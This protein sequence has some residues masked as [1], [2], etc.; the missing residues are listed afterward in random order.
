MDFPSVRKIAFFFFFFFFFPPPPPSSQQAGGWKA[1]VC[2]VRAAESRTSF[3]VQRASAAAACLWF[4]VTPSL[5]P[6][7]GCPTRVD[8]PLGQE[9]LVLF[10]EGWGEVI[11]TG[12]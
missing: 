3:W 12:K 11:S 5:H 4:G 6:G 2:W 10:G 9:G 1:P 8:G 7:C